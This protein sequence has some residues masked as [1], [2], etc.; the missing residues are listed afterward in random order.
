MI[1]WM[2]PATLDRPYRGSGVDRP[3]GVPLPPERLP[4]V[5]AGQLRKHWQYVSFWSRELS[6]CAA[7][8]DV[9]PLRKSTGDLGPR[10]RAFPAGRTFQQARAAGAGS[11]IR[12]RRR[13][14]D[15]RGVRGLRRLRGLPAR[16]PR[17]YLVA[18][19]LLPRGARRRSLRRH[20]AR[21]HSPNVRSRVS[22]ACS[23]PGRAGDSSRSNAASLASGSR[24]SNSSSE[25]TEISSGA[26]SRAKS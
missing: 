13:R 1:A 11:R 24:R 22:L 23:R 25:S 20:G 9:G 26:R 17:L 3:R 19:G 14:G 15:R 10:L 7:R 4:L 12:A 8:A 2:A 6:F 21:A 5:R 18:Q 16:G